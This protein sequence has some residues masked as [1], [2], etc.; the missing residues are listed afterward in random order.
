L[1]AESIH[2]RS[3]YVRLLKSIK[4]FQS[5]GYKLQTY[6]HVF[7]NHSVYLKEIEQ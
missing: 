6:C 7:M 2:S 4:I 1:I 3:K 5:Y